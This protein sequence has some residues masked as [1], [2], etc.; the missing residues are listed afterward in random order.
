MSARPVRLRGLVA[1]RVGF[2]SVAL[3]YYLANWR[4]RYFLWSGNGLFSKHQFE[5]LRHAGAAKWSLLQYVSTH[6]QLNVVYLVAILVALANLVAGGRVIGFAH[7]LLYLSFLRRNIFIGD[8]G[9]TMISTVLILMCFTTTNAYLSPGSAARRGRT[10]AQ[11]GAPRVAVTLHNTAVFLIVFQV[12]AIYCAASFWKLTGTLWEDGTA[13]YYI[14]HIDSYHV[15]WLGRGLLNNELITTALTY[16]VV[17][18]QLAVTPA[19]LLRRAVP[20][21]VA[22]LVLLHLGIT[23]A[24]GLFD[25]GLEMVVVDAILLSDVTWARIE[26]ALSPDADPDRAAARRALPPAAPTYT[27]GHRPV[28]APHDPVPVHEFVGDAGDT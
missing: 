28:D 5:Q 3:H 6:S 19:V 8:G 15:W 4:V 12:C 21:V 17:G 24:M 14:S 1:L 11:D 16:G 25:F 23:F 18:I 26:R 2:S 7:A 22:M 9:D 27:N 13:L 10:L 20:V